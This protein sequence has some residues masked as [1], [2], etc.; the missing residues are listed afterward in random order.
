MRYLTSN[1]V[2]FLHE[3][4]IR[5]FGGLAGLRDPAALESA[6]ARP[7]SGYYYNIYKKNGP[8]GESSYKSSIHRW[9]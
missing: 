2:I 7:A 8:N 4:V 9:E 1:E 6:L 3:Y 5:E